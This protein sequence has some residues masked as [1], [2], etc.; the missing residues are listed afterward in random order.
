MVCAS[1]FMRTS[2]RNYLS[3]KPDF[4]S[5]IQTA[6]RKVQKACKWR[7]C[8]SNIAFSPSVQL[9]SHVCCKEWPHGLQHARLFCPSL[10]PRAF[11]N[12]CPSSRWCHPTV[13]CSVI[14]FSSCLHSFPASGSFPMSSFI[15]SDGQSIVA[16]ATASV[17]PMNIKDWLP[18]GLTG[19][20]LLAVQGTP[21]SLLQHHSLKALIL[22]RSAF[23][24]VQF[25]RLY[26]ITGKTIDFTIWTFVSKVTSLLFNMLSRLVIAFLP[27]RKCLLISQLQSP[28]AVILEPKKIKTVTISIVSRTT[29]HG[30]V[31]YGTEYHDLCVLNV[32]F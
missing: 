4:G 30:K 28:S 32:E 5:V 7:I 25:S 14:S 29:C 13:S 1:I 18:L 12:S 26:I 17:L 27:R 9:F 19:F 21:E 10:T 23:F 24:M 31:G 22:W 8:L 16:S 15:A 11:S 20:D 3:R 2:S 6:L